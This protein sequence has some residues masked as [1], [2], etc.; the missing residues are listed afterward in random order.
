MLT[1]RTMPIPIGSSIATVA[2]LDT[3]AEITAASTPNAIMVRTGDP[4][5]PG[6]ESARSAIRRSSPCTLMARA[7]TKPPRNTKIVSVPKAPSTV[8]SS[9]T[10][11]NTHSRT[12]K[13][14]V[15]ASGSAS[16]THQ[17][18][19]STNTAASARWGQTSPSASRRTARNPSGPRGRPIR[20]RTLSKRL[21]P[22]ALSA[23]G[24]SVEPA[25]GPDCTAIVPT[26]RNSVS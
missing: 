22:A 9:A 15:T 16:V 8:S 18:M 5:M 19:T 10:P 6:T 13:T 17:T 25:R 3:N 23:S 2:V 26:F 14:A 7:I 4:A 1:E 20:A 24:A 12:A 21:L 11:R